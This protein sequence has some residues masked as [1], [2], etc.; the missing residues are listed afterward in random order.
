M[1][2]SRPAGSGGE[3]GDSPV[4]ADGVE[5]VNFA[6]PVGT[7]TFL[8]TDVEG[9]TRLWGAVPEAMRAA[10]ARHYELLDE[11]IARHGGVRPVEQGE[12]DSVVAAFARASD[13]LSA[14]TDVQRA[15]VREAWPQGAALR[16]RMALHTGEALRRDAGNYFGQA[17]IRCARLRAIAH[18]GQT[19]VSRTTR[20]L[21][22][23]RLPDG[24]QLVDLGVHRLRDLGRAEQ[25]FGLVHPELPAE[26]PPLRS[27]AT[28]PTNLPSELTSFVGRHSELTQLRQLLGQAR[29]LTLTG[30]GGC[31][32]TR[33]ALQAAADAID[34]YSD[35]VWWV[36]L[37]RVEDPTLVAAA[38]IAALGLGEA[39]GR[40]L[41]D[42]LVEYLRHRRLLLVL[43]N[44]EHLVEACAALV[45]ALLR[46]CPVL[47]VLATSR[48][49]L[50]CPA[51]SPGGCRQ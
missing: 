36:E 23:D 44:C 1:V 2:S 4:G 48:A 40:S 42:T 47:T 39:P 38:V 5:R 7:V 3:V 25:V 33:L 19:V 50:A 15:F 13:A 20:D 27:L 30:A 8:L 17:I 11:A 22:L 32:K 31:G 45:D 34:G 12:G 43:D 18:G 35:G 41:V 14:A 21:A 46:A 9:S 16:V 37:A 49:P 29:L 24:V 51:R 6:L 10:I 26:F 28:M